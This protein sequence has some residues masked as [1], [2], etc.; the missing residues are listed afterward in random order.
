MQR[1][2]KQGMALTDLTPAGFLEAAN[3][4]FF[5]PKMQDVMRLDAGSFDGPLAVGI[6]GVEKGEFELVYT[7]SEFVTVLSGRVIVTAGGKSHELGPGDVCFTPK[8]E[9]VRWNVLEEVRKAFI[10]VS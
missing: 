1:V 5:G 6:W 4:K 9:T 3:A 10:V 8:G 7:A 2:Y